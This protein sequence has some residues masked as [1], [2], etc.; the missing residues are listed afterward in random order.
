MDYRRALERCNERYGF[1]RI[2]TDCGSTLCGILLD[3]G[4]VNMISLV[5]A[6]AVM[7]KE[8]AGLFRKAGKPCL[9]LELLRQEAFSGGH[10]QCALPDIRRIGLTEYRPEQT[11]RQI[12]HLK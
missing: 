7:G 8:N 1:R 3:Q 5:I 11:C 9:N 12:F 6:P 4:L 2:I 10:L